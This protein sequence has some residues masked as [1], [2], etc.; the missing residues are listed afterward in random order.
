MPT[1]HGSIPIYTLLQMQYKNDG[2]TN[3]GNETLKFLWGKHFKIHR[4]FSDSQKKNN[5]SKNKSKNRKIRMHVIKKLLYYKGTNSPCGKIANRIE[6]NLRHLCMWP[7]IISWVYKET[8]ILIIISTTIIIIITE[9]FLNDSKQ[10]IL[11]SPLIY[12]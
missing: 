3:V 4:A 7:T 12:K 9:F 5:G 11:K 1:A 2:I 8:K 6:G 10:T